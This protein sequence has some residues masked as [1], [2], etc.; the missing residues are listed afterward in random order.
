MASDKLNQVGKYIRQANKNADLALKRYKKH[1]PVKDRVRDTVS[2]VSP[3]NMDI[4]TDGNQSV[5]I[6]IN[7]NKPPPSD[8]VS[9]CI[10]TA[11]EDFTLSYGGHSL[12]VTNPY[13]EGTVRVYRNGD[14][15]EELTQWYEEDP[16]AGKV[17]VQVQGSTETIAICYS[18]VTC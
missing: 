9:N 11:C 13:E 4:E 8:C 2:V 1:L 5:I 7:F 16:T 15:L 17:Y 3:F 18:Y 6:N 14:V 10:A 12:N